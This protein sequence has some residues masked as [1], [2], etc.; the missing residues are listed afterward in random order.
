MKNPV[1]QSKLFVTPMCEQ[2]LFDR[3]N[4]F[5]GQERALAF[6]VAMMTMNLCHSLVDDA[7]AQE[8]DSE[9]I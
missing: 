9:V 6:Q 1:P 5:T 2:D 3:L 4:Q 8:V 7:M